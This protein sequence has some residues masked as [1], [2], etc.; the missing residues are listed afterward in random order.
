MPEVVYVLILHGGPLCLPLGG[1]GDAGRP[2]VHGLAI[3]GG[4]TGAQPDT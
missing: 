3:T 1:E 2:L 4:L